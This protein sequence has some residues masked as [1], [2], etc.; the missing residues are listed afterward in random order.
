MHISKVSHNTTK[1]QINTNLLK[2]KSL[3]PSP[4]LGFEGMRDGVR[5]MP[6]R[7]HLGELEFLDLEE[8]SQVKA[9]TPVK[10]LTWASVCLSSKTKRTAC[11]FEPK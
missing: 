10:G 2:W 4:L 1:L 11:R 3:S 7:P 5:K 9:E 8:T 6:T